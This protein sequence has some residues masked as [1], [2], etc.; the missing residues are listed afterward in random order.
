M[1]RSQPTDLG[2]IVRRILLFPLSGYINRL[3]SIAS[4]AILADQLGAKLSVCW[5]PDS[6]APVPARAVLSEDFCAA[7]VLSS[8]EARDQFGVLRAAIPS[9]LTVDAHR[10]QVLLTG[11]DRGEQHFMEPLR[12]AMADHPDAESLVIAAGGKYFLPDGLT[13]ESAWHEQFRSL[14]HAF[15]SRLRLAETIESAVA[16]HLQS[17][18][19]YLGLHLRYTDRAHQSPSDRAVRDAVKL[20]TTESGLS[21]VFVAADS[22]TARDEW[23]ARVR[24]LGLAPWS[25]GHTEFD[26]STAGS[27]HAA[28]VDWRLLGSAARLVYFAE[29][30]FAE[31][32]AVAS[33]HRDESIALP[34]EAVR[35]ALV[36][37]RAYAES[38]R[39]YPRRHGWL[40]RPG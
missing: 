14:R 23:A 6:V 20:C 3:Q 21:S 2:C 27:E 18:G 1:T 31:E 33:G 12:S 26:R 25:A 8:D 9:Y 16:T 40:G 37:A 13:D 32:A 30:S 38:A 19:P 36:R 17:R 11:Y 35:S 39:T 34:A 4:S 22:P 29:S 24:T 15:Y 28:L 10:Q 5:E 7:H